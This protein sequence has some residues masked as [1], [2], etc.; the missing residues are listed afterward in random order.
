[1]KKSSYL[2]YARLILRRL[3]SEHAVSRS[4]KQMLLENVVKFIPTE[5]R[6][7][8]KSMI[9]K[10]IRLGLLKSKPKHYGV[11]VWLNREKF[12]EIEKVLQG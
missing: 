11:H 9:K 2:K 4:G 7:E 12:S 8:A 5:E 10:L 3:L 6:K 1:M